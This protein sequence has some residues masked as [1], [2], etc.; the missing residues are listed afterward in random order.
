MKLSILIGL[1]FLSLLPN[2][3]YLAETREPFSDSQAI[4]LVYKKYG[5]DFRK[6]LE[7]T[8]INPSYMIHH[9]GECNKT[10][11]VGTHQPH[12]WSVM[13]IFKVNPCKETIEL[14]DLSKRS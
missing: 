3:S 9:H 14:I 2:N 10:V 12:T 8:G 11:K 1:S 7:G 5:E 13:E 6:R 4:D